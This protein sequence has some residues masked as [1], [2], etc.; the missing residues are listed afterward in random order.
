VSWRLY[1]EFG[2]VFCIDDWSADSEQSS[3]IDAIHSMT[4]KLSAMI[5]HP[6]P[7]ALGF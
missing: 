6:I 2:S 4:Q 1:R 5:R 7:Y 3:P